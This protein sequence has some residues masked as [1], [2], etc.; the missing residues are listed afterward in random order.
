MSAI[1]VFPRAR[2]PNPSKRRP[3]PRPGALGAVLAI[4]CALTLPAPAQAAPAARPAVHRVS[5]LSYNIL[6]L[7]EFV[8][9]RDREKWMPIIARRSCP[10]NIVLF[11]EDFTYHDLLRRNAGCHKFIRQAPGAA[12]T[13]GGTAFGMRFSNLSKLVTG[14]KLFGSG[15]AVFTRHVVT[16]NAGIS[17]GVCKG[18]TDYQQ[19]CL[20]DKGAQLVTIKFASGISLDIYNTHL[21]AGRAKEDQAVRVKQLA[22]FARFVEQRSRN[23]P[24]IIAGDFNLNWTFPVMRRSLES[25]IK[26]LGLTR[27]AEAENP[28]N[29]IDHILY[30]GAG[31]IG[32]SVIS[33][34]LAR[35]FTVNGQPLSDHEPVTAT[36]RVSRG[37]G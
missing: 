30:R 33:A 37:P 5:V 8:A 29:P 23:R 7:P 20:S 6:G 3:L 22:M 17:Y 34:G 11:Q 18:Y 21:D 12:S 31:R 2:Q 14:G 28:K 13:T 36:F 1:R 10:Y 35:G 26:R 19:D 25:F 27:V 32:L 9:K 24:V 16:R 15:L 4:S